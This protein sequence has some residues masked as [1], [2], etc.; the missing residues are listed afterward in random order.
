MKVVIKSE[1]YHATLEDLKSVDGNAFDDGHEVYCKQ[2]ETIYKLIKGAIDGD[3]KLNDN[4]GY[5]SQYLMKKPANLFE[6]VEVVEAGY[7]D[8]TSIETIANINQRIYDYHFKRDKLKE[9]TLELGFANLSA[10][11]KA[12][13]ARYCAT[14]AATLVGY[15]MS[16]YGLTA[17]EA[18]SKYKVF[19]STD[20]SEAAKALSSRASNPVVMYISVKYM[21][22]AD[23]SAFTDAIRNFITDL[24]EVAHLG[25][26]YGQARDGIMDYIEATG[27]YTDAG[28]KSYSFENGYTYEQCRDEF[29]NYLVYG[30]KPTEFDVFSSS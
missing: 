22:E 18:T 13:V 12:I 19:R 14:D 4:T 21:S 17:A 8:L 20:I 29:K 9:L 23:A 3:V 7:T 6:F 5:F 2:T 25:T 15:F 16:Q 11:D 28:L 1:Q 10:S 26:N 27:S 30:I 24:K